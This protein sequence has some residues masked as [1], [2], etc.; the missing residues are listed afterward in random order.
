[1]TSTLTRKGS[2]NAW[3]KIRAR[4]LRRD[5]YT[6]Q[7]SDARC[8]GRLEVDHLET[9]GTHDGNDADA[10]LRTL[11][12]WHHKAR[13][14]G[15]QGPDS[16]SGTLPARHTLAVGRSVFRNGRS[17]DM[18]LSRLSLPEPGSGSSPQGDPDV[19]T[20]DYTRR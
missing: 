5:N 11:C 13:H 2:T 20:R 12:A 17:L 3:R 10:N 18:P 14:N 7:W 4:I 16:A 19:I 9:R 6:C 15:M 8:K 1:M